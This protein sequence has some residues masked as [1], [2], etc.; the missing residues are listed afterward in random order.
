MGISKPSVQGPGIVPALPR[1]PASEPGPGD[2]GATLVGVVASHSCTPPSPGRGGCLFLPWSWSDKFLIGC[3]L[4][5]ALSPGRTMPKMLVGVPAGSWGMGVAAEISLLG[6]A[7]IK[8]CSWKSS[9]HRAVFFSSHGCAAP[10]KFP[11]DGVCKVNKSLKAVLLMLPS[12]I[13]FTWSSDRGCRLVSQTTARAGLGRFSKLKQ[14][15]S[16]NHLTVSYKTSRISR[17][18]L[19]QKCH[20]QHCQPQVFKPHKSAPSSWLS[21]APFLSGSAELPG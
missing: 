6:T 8:H 10:L 2:M 18:G 19:Q 14:F 12:E 1:C 9:H 3:R 11:G 13:P 4:A 7:I 5:V 15:W 16:R 20:R 21:K 17:A